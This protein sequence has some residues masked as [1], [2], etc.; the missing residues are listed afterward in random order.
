MVK[1]LKYSSPDLRKL[2]GWILVYNIGDS[3]STKFVQIMIHVLGSPLTFLRYG[4][5]CV[6]VV[7]AIL[8]EWIA[9]HFQICNSCI[10]QVSE[11][12][13]M[14]RLFFCWPFSGGFCV[15]VLLCSCVVGFIHGICL[16]LL[17]PYLFLLLCLGKVVRRDCGISGVSSSLNSFIVICEVLTTRSHCRYAQ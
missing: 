16:S 7:A 2:Y 1:Y 10:Y 6:L 14:G 9:Y 13:S 17:V 5:I 15:T 3:K 12:W 4:Q 11:S 8:E